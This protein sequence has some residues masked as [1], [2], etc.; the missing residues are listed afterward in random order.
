VV[1]ADYVLTSLFMCDPITILKTIPYHRVS[2]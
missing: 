1:E 2:A